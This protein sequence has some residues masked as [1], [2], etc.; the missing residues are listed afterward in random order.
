MWHILGLK[1]CE[2]EKEDVR[3]VGSKGNFNEK[4]FVGCGPCFR[5]NPSVEM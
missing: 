5:M 3:E 4:A 2:I 1:N